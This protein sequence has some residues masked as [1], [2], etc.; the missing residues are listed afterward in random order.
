[1]II[2]KANLELKTVFHKMINTMGENVK[3]TELFVIN[4]ND[5]I[6]AGKGRS[7]FFNFDN[8]RKNSVLTELPIEESKAELII[9][10]PL[11]ENTLNMILYAFGKWGGIKGL[12]VEQGYDQLNRLIN[13]IFAEIDIE[14]ALT[15]DNFRFYKSG[16]Q[17]T[18]EEVIQMI[19]DKT[20]PVVEDE[21]EENNDSEN[22]VEPEDNKEDI[23]SEYE[24]GLWHNMFWTSGKFSFVNEE[25]SAEDKVK[26]RLGNDFYMVKYK[27][28]VCGEKLHMVVY[29]VGKEFRIETDV[30]AVYMTRAYTCNACNIYYT[31]KPHR[32]L[33]DGEVFQLNFEDDRK[34]YEDYLELLGREGK[35]TS[36]CNMNLYES[37]YNSKNLESTSDL[38]EICN[39]IETLSENEIIELKDKMDSGFY[40]QKIVD[41]FAK[42]VDTELEMRKHVNKTKTKVITDENVTTSEIKQESK[43]EK[44]EKAIFKNHT[45]TSDTKPER[46]KINIKSESI[47]LDK[48][49]SI[50]IDRNKYDNDDGT[51]GKRLSREPEDIQS[52]S[53]PVYEIDEPEKK[54]VTLENVRNYEDFLEYIREIE[55]EDCPDSIKQA[56][57]KPLREKLDKIGRQELDH[58]I[59]HIPENISKKQFQ[60]FSEKI[61]QYKEIDNRTYR[62]YLDEKRDEVEKQEIEVFIKKANAKTRKSL[63][64]LYN[65][66]KNS[67]FEDRN[68]SV[69]REK[70]YDKLYKADEEAIQLICPDPAD[71]TF[72]EGLKAYKEIEEGNF[73]PELK[74]NILTLID[75]RL[76]KMKIDE[77][78]QLVKKLKKEMNSIIQEDSRIYF[79]DVRKMI[80][81]NAR[82][83]ESIVINNA[84][85]KYAS[86]RG[87]YEYPIVICDASYFANGGVGFVLTPDHIFYNGLLSLGGIDVMNIENIY[88]DTGL[89]SKGIYVN[90]KKAGKVKIS[91]SLKS[92]KLKLFAKVLNDFVDYLKEK[93]ESRNISYMEKEKHAVKCCYRCGNVYKGNN[94]CPKCGSKFN[95]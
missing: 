32:L 56:K 38:E 26:S 57:L 81:G 23:Y 45:Q 88:A 89:L 53:K 85:N 1:M 5:I 58:I 93:P 73:L 51:V 86:D 28:P 72:D 78:E 94:I 12:K 37:E 34:A 70:I 14:A 74:T 55:N 84:L 48:K 66:L 19:L 42:K 90:Q 36:N 46:E 49:R 77:C 29:P 21:G 8:K 65:K 52:H 60:Q 87:K 63:F 39:D 11:L 10:N 92:N 13:S 61:N 79:F 30:E 40:P 22:A 41:K 17:V 68:V 62:L 15:T 80:K 3:W 95:E 54:K 9:Q 50:K 69:Y 7:L 44:S 6:L 16:L 18:Y 47:K 75:D 59:S 83:E 27:C 91:N 43:S 71:V 31:S 24:I 64:D 35:R 82:E 4:N 25:F 33:M 2:L 76:M 67:G 20:K